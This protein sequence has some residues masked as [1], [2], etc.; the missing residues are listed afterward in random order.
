MSN[1][2]LHGH[3][4]ERVYCQQPTGF[5]DAQRPHD[6]CLLSRS[7][8]GLR[9]APRAWFNRFVEHVKTLGFQQSRSD[10]SLFV[11]TKG[12]D[13]AY[14]LLYVDDMIL[15]A[16][17]TTLLQ[18]V[19]A[20][21]KQVFAIKDM[22]PI[23]YFLGVDVKSTKTSFFLSQSKYAL[24]IFERAGMANCKAVATPAEVKPKTSS[25]DG[26]LISDG[27]WYHSMAGAL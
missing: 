21:L 26:A 25:L 1:A 8:Y 24:D 2:F 6:V 18:A 5:E 14:L 12:S 22:D 15:S 10:S 3:L 9:Q 13:M 16:S 23:H 19:V 11:M 17:S 4:H 7:L 20:Q 27:S